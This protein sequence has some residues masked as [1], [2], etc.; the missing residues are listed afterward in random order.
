M[1]A[2]SKSHVI[3]QMA[4][5][6]ADIELSCCLGD[7]IQCEGINCQFKVAFV[8]QLL[9]KQHFLVTLVHFLWSQNMIPVRYYIHIK[10]PWFFGQKPHTNSWMSM[11][12]IWSGWRQITSCKGENRWKFSVRMCIA[13]RTRRYARHKGE[14]GNVQW[15]VMNFELSYDQLTM[16]SLISV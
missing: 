7:G 2:N 11:I 13:K 3:S 8:W 6:G 5:T 12:F 14:K 10:W 9:H 15:K 1:A 16:I 4:Y